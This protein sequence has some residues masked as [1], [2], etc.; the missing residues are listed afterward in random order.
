MQAQSSLAIAENV[1]PAL[2]LLQMT[3]GYWISRA[4]YVAARLE[5]SDLLK[6]GR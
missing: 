2:A 1:P 4:I 3:T 5:I 6:D